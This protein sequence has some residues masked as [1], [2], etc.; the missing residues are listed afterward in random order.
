MRRLAAEQPPTV[1]AA[2]LKRTVEA[3]RK[4]AV[5]HGICLVVSESPV[6]GAQRG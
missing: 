3:V 2:A 5:E 1:I 6:Q 4:K